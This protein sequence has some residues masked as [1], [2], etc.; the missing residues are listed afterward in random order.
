MGYLAGEMVETLKRKQPELLIDDKDVLCVKLAGL[1]HDL[2][3]YDSP[4]FG[5]VSHNLVIDL[6]Y[7]TWSIFTS[8]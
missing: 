7:R 1:C 3:I 8:L 4:T 5:M 2:G 6:L